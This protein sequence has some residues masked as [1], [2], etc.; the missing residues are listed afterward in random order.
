M[1]GVGTFILGRPRPSS[2]RRRAAT[3]TPSIRKSPIAESP[4]TTGCCRNRRTVSDNERVTV[5]GSGSSKRIEHARPT[6]ATVRQLYGTAVCCAKPRCRAPLYR[7]NEQSGEQVL[8]S[9][10]AH[11]HARSEGGPRW[12]P[13]MSEDDNRAPANLLLLCMHHAWEIDNLVDQFP[14]GVLR[15]W[16]KQQ[17]EVAAQASVTVAVSDADVEAAL[18][19]VDLQAFV[20]AVAASVPFHSGLRTRT[21]AWQL[22][23]RKAMGWRLARVKA[24]VAPDDRDT[25]VTWMATAPP[26]TLVVPPG[27]VRVLIGAMGAGK[28]EQAIRWW[29]E[30]LEEAISTESV[31]VGAFLIPRAINDLESAVIANLGHEP[32]QPCRVVID[33]LDSVSAQDASRLLIEARVLVHTW[34]NVSVLATARHEAIALAD[35][36]RIVAEP[37]PAKRGFSL[38]R[39]IL[40]EDF[41]WPDWNSETLDLL[42]SPLTTLGLAR[43]L[44]GGRRTKISRSELLSELASLTLEQSR[45]DLSEETWR[46]LARLAVV[47]LDQL[48]PVAADSFATLPRVQ[49]LLNTDLVVREDGGLRFALPV[50]EQYFGSQAIGSGLVA[51]ETAASGDAFP[52]WRY[53]LAFAVTTADAPRQEEF[54]LKLARLNPATVFW[55]LGEM[56]RTQDAV[57]SPDDSL[58]TTA[59][60]ALIANRDCSGI[61][62]EPS[63]PLRTGLWLREAEEALMAGLAPLGEQL[64]RRGRGLTQWGIW[65][66][67]EYVTLARARSRV[68][69]PVVEL[70]Q[71]HPPIGRTGWE[72]WRQFRFPPEQFG[73]WTCAQEHFQRRLDEAIQRRTLETPLDGWLARERA[74]HLAR[75]VTDFGVLHRGRPISLDD[76]RTKLATWVDR[77][78]ASEW[79]T[80]QNDVDSADVWWLDAYLARI[81]GDV[82]ERPWP[83]GDQPHVGRYSWESYSTD[84][85]ATLAAD[86][87]RE[88]LVGYRQLVEI[89]F[90]RFGSALG[91]YG[92]LPLHIEAFINRPEPGGNVSAVHMTLMLHQRP[93]T[94]RGAEPTTTLTFIGRDSNLWDRGS[95]H[96]RRA[97][98]TRFHR[99]PVQDIELPLHVTRPATNL[100]YQWLATDLAALGWLDTKIRYFN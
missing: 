17:I 36:E 9:H 42:C 13:L 100:A 75:F 1:I 40:G 91:L 56:N 32:N 89:N 47:I 72:S 24:M 29:E 31:D 33:D 5:A 25:V 44:K 97:T 45:R 46:E 67:N 50:F 39:T 57:E 11:I 88:A 85:T 84:L 86:I 74:Y 78:N 21:Q 62:S 71:I 64:R 53:A 68:S 55:I 92:M 94:T 87:L 16:K 83:V 80:W 82:L 70:D 14:A 22:A 65:L 76:L 63:A 96:Y 6:D 98:P 95:E 2:R 77:A 35:D 69:P 27:Q 93:G 66:G 34:P 30:G 12:D 37:W 54:L 26:P 43:R 23:T 15:E 18:A 19:P 60:E 48:G 79:S 99:S 41:Y 61:S 7:V 4:Q 20:D 59:I 51:L 38:L 58:H 90:P 8:N 73:R 3:P 49:A 81:A 28:T 10:V 52:R